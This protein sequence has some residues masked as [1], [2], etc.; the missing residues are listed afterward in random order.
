MG[1]G[2]EE[3]KESPSGSKLSTVNDSTGRTRSF[4]L[5]LTGNRRPSRPSPG[6]RSAKGE[7]GSVPDLGV[8]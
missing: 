2:D 3:G 1:I 7:T 4:D 6:G 5:K 8:A